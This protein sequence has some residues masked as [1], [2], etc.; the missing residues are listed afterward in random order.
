MDF[1]GDS[2]LYL[3]ALCLIL[4]YESITSESKYLIIY[5]IKKFQLLKNTWNPP[6]SKKDKK[7]GGKEEGEK[8]GR[9]EG[10]TDIH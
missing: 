3:F 2:N 6:N 4:W 9:K 8:E 1:I 10:Q 7:E 5:G